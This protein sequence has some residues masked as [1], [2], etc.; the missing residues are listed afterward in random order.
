MI[1]Q[2]KK[3]KNKKKLKFEDYYKANLVYMREQG[4][5]VA[6]LMPK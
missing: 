2:F 3:T 5:A 6:K 4:G 1:L